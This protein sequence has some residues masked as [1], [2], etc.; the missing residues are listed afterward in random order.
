[1]YNRRYLFALAALI[2]CVVASAQIA[3]TGN[4]S[5]VMEITPDPST[6]LNKIYVLNGT[7]GVGMSY[8][9]TTMN[10]VTW[11]SYGEQG[12]AYSQEI[13]DV[14]DDRENPFLSSIAQVEGN[15]GYIIE[16]GTSRRYVWVT[17]YSKFPLQLTSLT[18]DNDGDCGTA[19]L[20]VEGSGEDIPFYSITGVRNVLS[21]DMKLNYYNLL[22][23]DTTH[24][25][26]ELV[27]EPQKGFKHTIVIPAP[28]CNTT[29]T[30]SG[31]RFMEF[32]S[33]VKA[34][35]SNVYVTQA[36][37][38]HTTAVQ[39]QRENDNEKKSGTEGV[40]GGSAP[41]HITFTAYYTDAV[42]HKE[43][44]MALDQDFNNIVLRLNTDEVDETFDEAGT[45]YWR[46]IGSNAEGNCES[47]SETYTVN[48][49]ESE[50]VCPNV[51]TP[52][53][54]EGVNDVWKVS[55]R[56][57]I[58]FHCAIF[59]RWGNKI[60]EFD[61]PGQGWDG[62]YR[63][64]LVPAGVYYYV[65]KAR[66]SDGHVYNMDGDINI[67]RYRHVIS[68]SDDSGTSVVDPG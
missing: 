50:L 24:Y 4:T 27:T 33:K 1:M 17:D 53:S 47:Y 12:G 37:E 29:F 42:V 38:V 25:Q 19:T 3:F 8:T 52:G 9:A 40:L 34:V 56:S 54:S 20:H 13:F 66:G 62:T 5:E 44:Q 35:E 31:D 15:K 16:E 18:V 36:V 55:F 48:I 49:G 10:P 23:N 2:S 14:I 59:N 43:W 39:E 60:I 67:I 68:G 51:F 64:K 57:I 61:D 28:Y 45:T 65:I 7:E 26:Q 21:R 46:F 41:C 30:L 32:W 11:L 22:W 63:G 6:G 58:E